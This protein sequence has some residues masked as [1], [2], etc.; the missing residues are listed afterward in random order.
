[1]T[2]LLGDVPDGHRR[3]TIPTIWVALAASVLVHVALLLFAAPRL[4]RAAR[5]E[6]HC[7]GGPDL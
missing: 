2:I 3:R 4:Q 7:E 1:M 6:G 5:C